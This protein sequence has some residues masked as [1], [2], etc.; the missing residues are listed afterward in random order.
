ME[1]VASEVTDL[2]RNLGA[3]LL[4]RRWR[5]SVAESCTAGMVAAAITSVPGSS[6]YFTGGVIAYSNEIKQRVLGVPGKLL[7]EKGAVSAETAAA[8]A[9]GVARLCATECGIGVSGIA[10]P[11]G[12]TKEKPVGL[13]FI[14]IYTREQ[15]Q[16]F[17]FNFAGDREKIRTEATKAGLGKM[18]EGLES[19]R[20]GKLLINTLTHKLMNPLTH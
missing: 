10:G 4:Q 5:L 1:A 6:A 12:G 11:D 14:G 17:E 3:L 18:M 20:V 19:W 9:R 7:R 15:A 2:A 8:M 13:V 16:S